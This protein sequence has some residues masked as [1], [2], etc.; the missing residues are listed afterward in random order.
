MSS[1]KKYYE[2][3][4]LEKNA[5]ETEIKKA[6]R[7]LSLKHHPD[8]SS[9]PGS[10]ERFKEICKAYSTLSDPDKRRDYDLGKEENDEARFGHLSAREFKEALIN[11]VKEFFQEN[12]I[13]EK[14]LKKLEELGNSFKI[15]EPYSNCRN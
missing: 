14:T 10:E 3:L 12:K 2:I 7:K 11:D 15:Y 9:E 6:Y 1:K 13:S 5:S 4:E 8:K